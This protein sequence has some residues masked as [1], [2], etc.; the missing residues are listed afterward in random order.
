M[1]TLSPGLSRFASSFF[2]VMPAFLLISLFV[3]LPSTSAQEYK[4]VVHNVENIF[5]I[6]GVAVYSDYQPFDEDGNPLYRPEHLLTKI[7]KTSRL[8]ARYNDGAGPE[9]I[10]FVEI[11]SDFTPLPEFAL[12]D[13]K[14]VLAKYEHLTIEQML[15]TH[16]DDKIADLPAEILLLKGMHDHG[17]TGYD[18][19]VAYERDESGRPTH[20]VKNVLFSRFPILHDRTRA[21]PGESARPTLEAWVDINGSELA[22]FVNH[23]RS[24]ASDAEME[25]V[26]IRNA[27]V[28]RDRLDELLDENPQLDF[29]LGGDFNSQYHQSHRY[30]YMEITAVNDVLGSVGDERGVKRGENDGVYNLWYELPLDERGSDVFRGSWGTLM[31][32]MI[33]KGMYDFEGVQYVDNS[34]AVGRWPGKNVYANSGAPRR[35]HFFEVGGGYSDHLPVSMRFQLADADSGLD[36]ITLENPG[37]NDDEDSFVIPIQYTMPDPSDVIMPETYDGQELRTTA[38]FDQLFLVETEITDRFQVRVNGELYDLWAPAFNVRERFAAYAGAGNEIQFIARLGKFRG[39][40]QFVI[41]SEEY[42]NP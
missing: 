15:T 9:L 24:R 1:I 40:W 8:M 33:G 18:V 36:F 13:S 5:D 21:L 16:L 20:A 12:H 26:R 31:Q 11:E 28:L 27:Q 6:D 14:E 35:W 17:L 19:A 32:I 22:L 37:F 3:A 10:M 29:I 7:Q 38:F 23:W 4:L 41:E 30:P 25:L 34:F 2:R 42:I 39:N